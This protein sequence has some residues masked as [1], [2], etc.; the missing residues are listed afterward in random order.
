MEFRCLARRIAIAADASDIFRALFANSNRSYWLDSKRVDP[1]KGR[2]SFMGDDSGPHSF[3]VNQCVGAP[4]KFHGRVMPVPTYADD[5]FDYL[6]VALRSCTLVDEPELPFD[7]RGG[8][9]GFFGYELMALTEGIHG[10]RSPFADAEFLFSDRFVAIDH[11]DQ[12]VYLVMLKTPGDEEK[13]WFDTVEAKLRGMRSIAPP[14]RATLLKP[15]ALD[16]YLLDS[17][18]GYLDKIA[19]CQDEIAAGESYEICLTSRVR[20]PIE[21][22]DLL[23]PFELY[24]VLRET[25]PAP[26]SCFLRGSD[27]SVLC[28]SPERFLK[29]DRNGMVEARP[30]KGTTPRDADPTKDEYNR[31]SLANDTRYFSENLMIVDLLRNDLSRSCEPGSVTVPELMV[32]ESYAT[33]HQLVSTIRGKLR[34]SA[35]R[36]VAHCFPGGSMTGA[37]KRRTLEILTDLED[38]PRGIYSGAIG[39]LSL[40]SSVDLNIVIRTMVVTDNLVEIGVGGAITFLSDPDD[41]FE[42]MRLKAIAPFSALQSHLSLNL[43]RTQQA[44]LPD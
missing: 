26:Y 15:E 37:P 40:N 21:Q 9:V 33:V 22:K 43:V 27:S 38:A 36:C 18:A 11:V 6:D 30:I 3:V 23:D 19:R 4:P 14:S 42:E 13:S 35:L 8:Y 32:T 34:D 28:S 41:E 10:K 20:V 5:I 12:H 25:N 44:T 31:S 1:F 7:F 29:I 2:Y 39:Y 24:L 16:P 17:R